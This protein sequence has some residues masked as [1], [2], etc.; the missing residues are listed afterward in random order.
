MAIK[1]NQV[2]RG[3]RV[4]LNGNFIEKCLGDKYLKDEKVIFISDN[5]IY[6]DSYGDW[7]YVEGGSLI[8]TGRAYIEQLDLEFPIPERPLYDSWGETRIL[9]EK[10]KEWW[11]G[12]SDENQYEICSIVVDSLMVNRLDMSH[13]IE[14]YE[15]AQKISP[16]YL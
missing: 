3:V 14:C 6:N 15:W 9:E 2:A 8:N 12:L 5:H 13:I 4:K 10:A 1:R 16:K 7:V 11:D